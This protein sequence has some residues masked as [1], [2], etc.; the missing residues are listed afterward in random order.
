MKR[1][2]LQNVSNLTPNINI[3][4]APVAS[5]THCQNKLDRSFKT[6]AWSFIIKLVITIEDMQPSVG[7]LMCQ[8]KLEWLS[9]K[10]IFLAIFPASLISSKES[11]VTC[12]R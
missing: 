8:S 3:G 12:C 2:S 7:N 9:F 5:L 11:E 4:L 6:P 10:Q 1:S